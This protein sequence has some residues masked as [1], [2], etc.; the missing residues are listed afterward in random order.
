MTPFLLRW[1]LRLFLAVAI[2]FLATGCRDRGQD[3]A[4]NQEPTYKG[5]AVTYLETDQT[6]VRSG[7]LFTVAARV[8]NDGNEPIYDLDLGVAVGQSGG[9]AADWET[10]TENPSA[11]IT[12]LTPG[13]EVAYDATVRLSGSGWYEVGIAGS[14]ANTFL[15]PQGQKILVVDPGTAIGQLIGIFLLFVILIGGAGLLLASLLRGTRDVTR[16][17]PSRRVIWVGAFLMVLGVLIFAVLGRAAGRLAPALLFTLPLAAVGLFLLG[18]LVVGA[19]LRV[20]GSPWR[21][22][23]AAG[24]LYVVI[25]VVWVFAFNA[26]LGADLPAMITDPSW[27]LLSLI[28]PMQVAQATGLFG[29][30]FN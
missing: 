4:A 19:G 14:A 12:E 8:L 24:V 30:A 26:Q 2:L 23:V 29:L 18:W 7:S 5:L 16:S 3:N 21:G 10:V 25:G 15:M 13:A 27:V 1:N 22:A 28:W 9:T 11:I 6:I 17:K 20:G